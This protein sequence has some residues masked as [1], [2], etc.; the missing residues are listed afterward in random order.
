MKQK[1]ITWSL[2]LVKATFRSVTGKRNNS[3]LQWVQCHLH[4]QSL[5][6]SR[7][8][9]QH[10]A[11]EARFTGRN[12]LCSNINRSNCRQNCLLSKKVLETEV[13]KY[14]MKELY[15]LFKNLKYDTKSGRGKNFN[16][17][18]FQSIFSVIEA[19][20]K[21]CQ[22]FLRNPLMLSLW[23]RCNTQLLTKS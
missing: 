8:K 9:Q 18:W 12:N 17:Y 15:T 16:F 3:T 7:N 1:R 6:N 5:V 19:Q 13:E 14:F 2:Q 21:K 11:K 4:L 22:T 20:N 10:F 23:S